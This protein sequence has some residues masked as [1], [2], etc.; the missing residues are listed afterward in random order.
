MPVTDLQTLK[1]VHSIINGSI[2]KPEFTNYVY[3]K[4]A[5]DNYGVN[6]I[7]DLFQYQEATSQDH[8]KHFS[9]VA[10]NIM[11][12]SRKIFYTMRCLIL[13]FQHTRR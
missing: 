1:S 11:L 9:A 4:E 12:K 5:L 2:S 10:Y 8:D 3:N 6:Q 7:I 13:I